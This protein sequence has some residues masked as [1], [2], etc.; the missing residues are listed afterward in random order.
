MTRDGAANE[1][2]LRRLCEKHGVPTSMVQDMIE[3]ERRHQFQERR[4]GI[5]DELAGVIRN[6][7]D[8]GRGVGGDRFRG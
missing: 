4:H 1:E 2:L 7:I 8:D 3:I 5:Y 6:A